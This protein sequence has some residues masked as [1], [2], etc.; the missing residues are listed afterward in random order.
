MLRSAT[1]NL[2]VLACLL[3]M[4]IV[5]LGNACGI[6]QS[7]KERGVCRT[8]MFIPGAWVTTRSVQRHKRTLGVRNL[9]H[10][11]SFDSRI[12]SN[13]SRLPVSVMLLWLCSYELDPTRHWPKKSVVAVLRSTAY[14]TSGS[15]EV[16]RSLSET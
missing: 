4:G 14:R 15:A 8:K 11:I 13:L 9:A 5:V 3:P 12:M 16:E 7:Y 1:V 2:C 6:H 10:S